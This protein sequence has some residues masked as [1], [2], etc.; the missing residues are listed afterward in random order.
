MLKFQQDLQGPLACGLVLPIIGL[1]DLFESQPAIGSGE[2]L[3]HPGLRFM[4][5][6]FQLMKLEI[7]ESL[8]PGFLK[9]LEP[10]FHRHSGCSKRKQ[11]GKL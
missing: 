9:R 2:F 7:G 10:V 6:V 4:F 3:M 11:S 8:K 1:G 5:R